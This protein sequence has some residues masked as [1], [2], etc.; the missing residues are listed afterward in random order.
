MLNT[1]IRKVLHEISDKMKLQLITLEG[2]LLFF[3]C[4]TYVFYL[5]GMINYAES[6]KQYV[7]HMNLTK[8]SRI[9]DINGKINAQNWRANIDVL[10][11]KNQALCVRGNTVD[12][13]NSLFLFLLNHREGTHH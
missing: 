9:L 11:S 2:K 8:E 10:P 4:N 3:I 7:L 12:T 13:L 5:L 1:N 6:N